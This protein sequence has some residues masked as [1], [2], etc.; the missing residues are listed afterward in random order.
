M[1]ALFVSAT[2]VVVVFC[3]VIVAQYYENST[4]YNEL[5]VER[6]QLLFEEVG[7]LPFV[8]LKYYPDSLLLFRDEFIDVDV[9]TTSPIFGAPQDWK[10]A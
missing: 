5:T 8:A 6:E 3:P 9:Y 10:I 7:R 2:V 4:R 1:I